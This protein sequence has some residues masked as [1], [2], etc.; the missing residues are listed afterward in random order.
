MWISS[1]RYRCLHFSTN[2]N[3]HGQP[4][5][6]TLHT[7]HCTPVRLDNRHTHTHTRTRAHTRTRTHTHTHTH[8]HTVNAT[9]QHTMLVDNCNK[10]NRWDAHAERA[11]VMGSMVWLLPSAV[12]SLVLPIASITS[13]TACLDNMLCNRPRCSIART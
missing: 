1:V 3:H 11:K 5:L 10:Y 2:L 8:V 13:P 9:T 6:C 4:S 7:A 12:S